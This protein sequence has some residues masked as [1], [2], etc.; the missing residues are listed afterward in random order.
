MRSPAARGAPA[1]VCAGR[2]APG[3]AGRHRHAS[4]EPLAGSAD[5]RHRALPEGGRRAPV[6]RLAQQHLLA[7]RARG[8]AR[9]RPRGQ[10]VRPPASRSARAAGPVGQLAL[11]RRALLRAALGAHADLH[12]ELPS[13]RHPRPVR[14]LAGLRRLRRLPAADGLDRRADPDLVERPPAPLLRHGR[15]A[16]LRCPDQRRRFQRAR[17]AGGRLCGPGGHRRGGGRALRR[18]SAALHRGELLARDPLRPR[19]QA[20][21]SV[22]GDEFPAAPVAER[23]LAWTAPARAELGVEPV[24]P[25]AN[26]AQRQ[27]RAFEA[28]PRCRRSTKTRSRRRSAP[29]RPRR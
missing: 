11:P 22:R 9:R 5:H 16:H 12:Q 4:V 2:P 24:L 27:R 6:R 28:V 29:T 7:A 26:G 10:G 18:S 19:R 8:R 14:G 21:R 15:A 23:L 20:D 25:E 17:G 3:P 13:L 1:P